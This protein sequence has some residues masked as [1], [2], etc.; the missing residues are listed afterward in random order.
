MYGRL[1]KSQFYQYINRLI[2]T[3]TSDLFRLY[4]SWITLIEILVKIASR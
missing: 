2:A 4:G 3:I 1:K